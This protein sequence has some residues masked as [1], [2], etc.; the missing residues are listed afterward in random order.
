LKE[1]HNLTETD[2]SLIAALGFGVASAAGS[3]AILLWKPTGPPDGTLLTIAVLAFGHCCAG[4]ILG[5]LLRRGSGGR[6]L[7]TASLIGA[8]VPMLALILMFFVTM[9][10]FVVSVM[11]GIG[12]VWRLLEGELENPALTLEPIGNVMRAGWVL[13]GTS[14]GVG[15]IIHLFH[16][17]R[18]SA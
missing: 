13:V 2:L 16:R 9:V 6:G 1:D 10:V 3:F 7:A 14:A 18:V 11:L 15:A 12:W 17:N 4:L 5:S 8:L